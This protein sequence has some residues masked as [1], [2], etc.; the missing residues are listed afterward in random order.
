M[1]SVRKRHPDGISAD[2][3]RKRGGER[4]KGYGQCR[5]IGIRLKATYCSRHARRVR[6]GARSVNKLEG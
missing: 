3:S 1:D 5:S 2:L 4:D 6:D